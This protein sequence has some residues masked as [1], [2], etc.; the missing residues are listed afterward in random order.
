MQYD[1][2]YV[3][4]PRNPDGKY[5]NLKT[6]DG[7]TLMCPVALLGMFQAGQVVDINTRSEVWK[8]RNGEPD[9]TMTIVASGP[10]G[11]RPTPQQAATGAAM[12]KA[13]AGSGA[14]VVGAPRQDGPS[15]A[16][17]KR[18][19]VSNI[20]SHAMSSGKFTASEIRVL[21]QGALE[22]FD[23]L[24]VPALPKV[25]PQPPPADDFPDSQLQ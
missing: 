9:K 5:G 6:R 16:E 11:A 10:G 12:A 24:T 22:A 4:G 3:N 25:V 2:A 14:P 23:M 21:T 13:G 1:I 18:M 17:A 15:P 7:L 8:G 19:F 20:V